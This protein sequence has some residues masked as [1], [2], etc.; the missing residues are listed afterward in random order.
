MIS[1][2][3]WDSFALFQKGLRVSGVPRG[4]QRVTHFL[5]LP[6][7]YSIPLMGF[8]TLLHWLIS[9]SIFVVSV[10]T[11]SEIF[12]SGGGI[13]TT[14]SKTGGNWITCGYAL[15]PMMIVFLLGFVLVG[16]AIFIGRGSLHSNIPISL[17]NSRIIATECHPEPFRE[18]EA[19]RKLQWGPRRNAID[20]SVQYAFSSA[21]VDQDIIGESTPH[22]GSRFSRIRFRMP[23][24]SYDSVKND[25]VELQQRNR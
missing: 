20:G 16:Y 23:F 9:Q 4:E 14:I 6:Y 11:D 7:R 2:S 3:E 10:V 17:S 25:E 21:P 18:G 19:Y 5:Q 15:T 8:S 1:A 13:T 12:K 22:P 24:Q